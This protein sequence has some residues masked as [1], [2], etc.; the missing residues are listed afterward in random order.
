MNPTSQWILIGACVL[1]LFLAVYVVWWQPKRL[2]ERL[3]ESLKAFAKAV[4]LR[5]PN[6]SGLTEEVEELSLS[7]G[8]RLGFSPR[9]LRNLRMATYLR[10]IG[11]CATPYRLVNDRSDKAWTASDKAV[12]DRHPEVGSA[13]LQL[14]PSLTGL[15]E[16]V[17]THH[18]SSGRFDRPPTVNDVLPAT[19]A[20]AWIAKHDGEQAA[21]FHLGANVGQL[22]HPA[23]VQAIGSQVSSRS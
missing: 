13:M 8:S 10:D 23:V 1:T 5:F 21:L 7:V 20:Y 9:H 12:Y 2:D 14:I 22:Y 15:A 19:T 11:L 16:I 17:R 3:S 18:E 6:H 4:E